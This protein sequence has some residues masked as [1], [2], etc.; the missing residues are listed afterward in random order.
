MLRKTKFCV[1]QE[2]ICNVPIAKKMFLGYTPMVYPNIMPRC[3]LLSSNA[4]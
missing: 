3:V 4:Q 2:L 1:N